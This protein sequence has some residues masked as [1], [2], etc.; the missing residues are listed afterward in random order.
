MTLLERIDRRVGVP[1]TL[2]IIV[3]VATVVGSLGPPSLDRVVLGALL[4]LVF[5]VGLYLFVGNSGIMSFGHL[6]FA[7]VGAY[8]AGLFAMSEQSKR[9]LVPDAPEWLISTSMG[10]I[11]AVLVAGLVAALVALLVVVP[12]SRISGL[13]AGIATVSLL[14]A[15]RVIAGNWES[16]TRGKKSLADIP[17]TTTRER[18]LLWLV[19]LIFVAW[20]Y[21]RSRWGRQLRAS[22]VD[23]VAAASVGISVPF[24]RGASFVL[25]AFFTGV[26]GGLFALSLGS[27]GPDIFYLDLTFLVIAMLVV[28][29]VDT[30][31]GAVLGTVGVSILAEIMRRIEGG[32]FIG[33]FDVPARPGIQRVVVGAVLLLVLLRRP[34]GMVG[35][36][37]ISFFSPRRRTTPVSTP[38]KPNQQP[39]LEETSDV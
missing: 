37:E 8:A 33:L 4:N 38:A 16:I 31:S 10:S 29:G 39:T 36:R 1:L 11:A 3:V 21:Q 18:A 27:V 12:L 17:I 26:G 2:S 14:I 28:G 13:A 9:N 7:A 34:R 6:A 35:D 30:L 5:V 25:S 23:E 24:Q 15:T 20:G 19:V 32:N 22:K